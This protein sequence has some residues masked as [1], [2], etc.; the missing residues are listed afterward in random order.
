MQNHMKKPEKSVQSMAASTQSPG[1]KGIL[2]LDAHGRRLVALGVGAEAE[3]QAL[4]DKP[5]W[6]EHAASKRFVP[7]LLRGRKLLALV[8]RVDDG[9]FVL[10]SEGPTDTVLRL[11]L[12]VDFAYDIIDHVLTDPYDA[13]VVVNDKAQLAF[14]SP[15]HEK[16]FG[17]EP[18]EG[19]G[20][21]VREIMPNSRLGHVVHTGIAEVGQL[22]RI[23]DNERIVSRHPI[24][25]Q[26]RIV[27]A[28]GRIMFK[29]PQQVEELYRRVQA[30]EQKIAIYQ[31][32]SSEEKRADKYLEIIIG[33]SL[34]IQSVRQQI[35]KM[36][37]LDVPVLIQGD[38]GT[39]KEL[40]AR[41]LHM[42]SPRHSARLVTVNTA[43]LPAALVESELFGY[44]A[45]SFTGAARKGREGKFELA[46]KGTIFLDEIG[47]MPLDV[48]SKL[49][50]VL[51]DRMV[52]RVGADKAKRVDFR[53]VS[54]TNRDL[55]SFVEQN[56]FRLDLF[57]RI[58]PVRI[59]LP[60]LEERIEDIP[61]LLHHFLRE[62]AEKYGRKLPQV[63]PDVPE[64]LM[65]RSWPGNIRQLQ[66]EVERAFV[67]SES[68]QL[69]VAD[70]PKDTVA[71]APR[72]AAARPTTPLVSPSEPRTRQGAVDQL[73]RDLITDAM[74]RFKG[75]KK[76]VAEHLGI[77][78]SYLYKKLAV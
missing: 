74:A 17:L 55:E 78:R 22:H 15:V 59:V 21:D 40:V 13:M 11:L 30:L 18:G 39:G 2:V 65:N 75:N 33:Q 19:N 20:K 31:M 1:I 68:E 44:E 3:V 52:E 51:Q 5:Q 53:L 50:R 67:F 8:T 9:Y 4:V 32:E 45:G 76:K 49:L 63:G 36:A 27:G 28:I 54:A 72:M 66:H 62:L 34:A 77:S 26:G 16:F 73:D 70:F 37:P 61:L 24:R 58:S 14:L 10:L 38:S 46:D 69:S 41:A 42:L 6:S 71:K 48:Q 43:A 35:R 29:G 57:Y 60:T 12:S 64:Y 7:L 23:K 25:H 56:K 47:D